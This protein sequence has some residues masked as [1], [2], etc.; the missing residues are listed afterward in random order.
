MKTVRRGVFTSM[1]EENMAVTQDD[2]GHGRQLGGQD[3]NVNKATNVFAT[4]HKVSRSKRGEIIGSRGGFRG[5]TIWFTGLSGAGKT[6][7]AFALEEYLVARGIPAYGL[8]G[9][10][11]RTGLNK[12][13]GFAPEDREENIRRVAEVGKLFADSGVVALCSFVSPYNKDRELARQL[14]K[15]CGLPFF[16]IHVAT[17]LEECEKRDV[18]GLYKKARAGLIKGFTG[19]DQPYESPE[20]PEVIINTESRTVEDC[21]QQIV[22]VLQK[23]DILPQSVVEKVMDLTIPEENLAEALAEAEQLPS[24][25]ITK[26]D[27]QWLQVLGEGWATPLTG[28][29]RERE[30]LQCQHFNCLLDHGVTNQS[31]PVVLPV[32][33]QDKERLAGCKEFTLSYNGVARAIIRDPEFYEHRKEERCARQFGMFNDGH[34]YI[35]M[36]SES[37]DWL[38]GGEVEVL[39]RI[40]WND[41]LDHYR[42][43]PTELRA[44][45]KE[46]HADAV[47]AF[48]LRN[49]V[50]NGHALLMNDCKRQLVERGYMK[51][52]LLLH[53]LGGW[54]KDDDV[55]L[56]VRMEQ[57]K[58]IMDEGVLDPESTVLAIFPSPMMYAGPTEVQWH[59]KA[60]MSTGA[61]F[62]IV[63]RDP[64]G[65][66]HPSPPKQDIY[67]ATHGGKVL[68]MAPGLTQLEIIPFKVAAYDKKAQAMAFFDP[69][70][71]ED[72]DFISGTRMRSLAKAGEMPP[73]GFMA[74][75]AWAVLARYY[76]SGAAHTAQ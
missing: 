44:K 27:L 11:V 75:S 59:A 36:I 21:V 41:G 3:S 20:N 67:E 57:H 13:L 32:H 29:M 51:P 58:A 50:H 38:V 53:P 65:M 73:T 43:T 66:P 72:F 1:L 25:E 30:F 15:S 7:I 5:C 52:V 14:H 46:M 71:R 45:F 23:N 34:P 10:N 70:R 31:V 64:A 2:S 9:D 39:G 49:P 48:Q 6:T 18:K 35:K 47:F 74:P 26:L 55:P 42:F 60:R 19:I 62:Y 17:S 40:K 8:D 54:T 28:F 56:S 22:E 33:T 63:G 37:G 68:E 16:E 24:V 61:N 69:H 76:Q 4:E 12:N